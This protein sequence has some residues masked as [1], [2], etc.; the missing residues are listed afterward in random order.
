MTAVLAQLQAERRG[1]EFDTPFAGLSTRSSLTLL[2]YR[3]ERLRT[4]FVASPIRSVSLFWDTEDAYGVFAVV[5]F[6]SVCV[7]LWFGRFG[8][9]CIYSVTILS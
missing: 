5:S 3:F 6:S 8:G 1:I 2:L 7:F 9:Q 4:I